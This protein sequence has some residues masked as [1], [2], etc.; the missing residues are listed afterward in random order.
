MDAS[1]V[2]RAVDHP[3]PFTYVI[4][5]KAGMANRMAPAVGQYCVEH[6]QHNGRR[7]SNILSG[8][9]CR[10]HAVL[11]THT[12]PAPAAGRYHARAH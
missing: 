6:M 9:V 10:W 7:R 5:D 1:L 3:S 11:H 12:R 8:F 2:L 4:V